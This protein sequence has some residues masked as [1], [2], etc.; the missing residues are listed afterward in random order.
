MAKV[1]V[2]VRARVSGG[3][4]CALLDGS[5]DQPA[6]H[7]LLG[8]IAQSLRDL[9]DELDAEAHAARAPAATSG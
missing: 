6:L 9:A 5:D 1:E 2:Q 4:W 8:N 3:P 7:P